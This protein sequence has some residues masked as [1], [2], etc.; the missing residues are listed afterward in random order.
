VPKQ[1]GPGLPPSS[2][3][4]KPKKTEPASEKQSSQKIETDDKNRKNS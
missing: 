4:S 2:N 3:S 1:Q